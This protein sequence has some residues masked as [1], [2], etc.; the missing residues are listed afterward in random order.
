MKQDATRLPRRPSQLR[1]V[2]A[3]TIVGFVLTVLGVHSYAQEPLHMG[4]PR[5]IPDGEAAFPG[6][7]TSEALRDAKPTDL[8]ISPMSL[9]SLIQEAPSRI[10]ES[11][12]T[13]DARLVIDGPSG[14][15]KI[16]AP[17]LEFELFPVD[18]ELKERPTTLVPQPRDV[19][20][21]RAPF[22]SSRVVP[23]YARLS[24]PYN[25]VGRLFYRKPDGTEWWCSGAVV[26]FRLVLTAGHCVHRG[27][28][29]NG[30][31]YN[32]FLFVPAFHQNKAPYRAWS[33]GWVFTTTSWARSK[34]KV[35]NSADI[36]IIELRDEAIGGRTKKIGDV[37]GGWFGF[38]TNSLKENHTKKI[39]YPGNF[40]E[41]RIMRQVDSED[42]V[43][44][45]KNTRLYGSD[46]RGGSSGGPWVMNFGDNGRDNTG[47]LE[48]WRPNRV[49]GVTSYGFKDTAPKVQGS[50]NLGKEFLEMYKTACN[51][52]K[53][54]C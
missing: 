50:S 18:A 6:E 39:G 8:P 13:I 47:G 54:N 43:S 4:N 12:G 32:S 37:V 29:G 21:Q 25:L 2:G 38:R 20:S 1:S 23:L 44:G 45:G 30:G 49:V 51:R 46:M 33:W 48:P 22:S 52:R 35:P 42:F 34:N 41:G 36:A 14:L 40:D 11:P 17:N 9:Q 19:G 24:Y 31:Y 16:T 26:G 28:G 3:A 15:G 27:S 10:R 7:W 5:A 53:G